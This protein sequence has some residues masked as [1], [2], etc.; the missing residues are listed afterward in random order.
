RHANAE[1]PD[2]QWT[3]DFTHLREMRHQLAAGLMHRLD[4]AARKLELTSRLERDR[5]A[6]G[7][8]VEADDVVALHD[9]LPAEQVAHSVEQRL[10]AAR[11]RVGHGVMAFERERE[12]FVFGTDAKIFGRLRPG[13]E[14][15]DKCVARFNGR[16]VDLI[17]SHAGSGGNGARPY[18]G[19]APKSN[20][21]A[22][23]CIR[24]TAPCQSGGPRP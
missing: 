5:A 20:A 23:G 15:R 4:R 24:A 8:I 11:P 18:T 3:R 2:P 1:K 21:R 17:A 10:D 6:T 19:L 12:L 13:L 22:V 16:H 9:R 7:H 14:P